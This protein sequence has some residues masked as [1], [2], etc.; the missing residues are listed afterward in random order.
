M[1]VLLTLSMASADVPDVDQPLRSGISSPLDAAVIVGIED[2]AF[3]PDVPYA[4][5]DAEGVYQTMVYTRG[6]PAE[7]VQLLKSAN[8]DQVLRAVETAA[9]QAGGQ[10]TVWVYF[11]GHGATAQDGQMMLVGDDAKRDASVFE[12]R[13]LTVTELQDALPGRAVLMLD[14]CQAGVGRDGDALIADARFAVPTYTTSQVANHY[15]WT[16]ASPSEISQGYEPAQHGLFT[17]FMLGA[18]RGWADGELDGTP[19]GSVTLEESQAFVRR[20]LATLNERNQTPSLTGPNRGAMSLTRGDRLERSP[21]LTSLPVMGKQ[22]Q[23]VAVVAS[24]GFARPFSYEGGNRF[25]DAGGRA[26][27]QTDLEA[28]ISG[29]A[30]GESARIGMKRSSTMMHAGAAT[31][32]AGVAATGLG[33]LLYGIALAKVDE[34]INPNDFQTEESPSPMGYVLPGISVTGLGAVLSVIGGKKKAKQRRQ[35]ARVA[36]DIVVQ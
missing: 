21:D 9:Q 31:T 14:T 34:P 18:M 8:R 26:L 25:A 5:R 28:L 36:S 27:V 23:M 30:A 13:S 15:L 29:S 32:A 35:L 2:Y 33:G 6:V 4:S 3:L 7:R 10:G 19:N 12:D 17:Y 1:F 11:A 24:D 22:N 20:A 16:A